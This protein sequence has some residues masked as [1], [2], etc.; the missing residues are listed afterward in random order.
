MDFQYIDENNVKYLVFGDKTGLYILN[1]NTSDK[2]PQW[3]TYSP[4][5]CGDE[6]MIHYSLTSGF[7]YENWNFYGIS[8]SN[9][10]RSL[11]VFKNGIW[12]YSDFSM[13]GEPTGL[14]SLPLEV[15][16]AAKDRNDNFF[17]KSRISKTVNCMSADQEGKVWFGTTKGLAN[18]DGSRF[19]YYDK[20]NS[21]LPDNFI[22]NLL[23]DKKNRIWVGT[24]NG[25]LCIDKE[26]QTL[27][28]KKN[29]LNT[30][31]I[32]A[33][34]QNSAGKVFIATSNFNSVS[35]SIC[36]EEN[37]ILKEEPLPDVYTIGKMVLTA[38]IISG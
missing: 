16:S 33:L 14:L 38:T 31:R 34:A 25:L 21:Q 6:A 22:L 18:Y 3:I 26:K 17:D 9:G 27:Y 10:N 7:N 23:A 35:K 11:N 2:Y 19:T 28:D 15:Q 1:E 5:R 24:A 8:H 13:S 37:G 12:T 29:G 32:V 20:K 36:Y 4:Y 30:E